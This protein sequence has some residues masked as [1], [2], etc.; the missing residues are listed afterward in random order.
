M[1]ATEKQCIED[2]LAQYI[3]MRAQIRK[4]FQRALEIS[5]KGDL[6]AEELANRLVCSLH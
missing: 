4:D 6:E 2:R 5:K 1:D 3:S